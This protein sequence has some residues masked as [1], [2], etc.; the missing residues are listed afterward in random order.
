MAKQSVK[1]GEYILQIEDNGHVNVV[2]IPKN[3]KAAMIKIAEEKG[4]QYDPKW[5]TQY[6]GYALCK[7]YGD[8][9]TATF[10]D[11]T[12]T[13]QKNNKIEIV[14]ECK[15]VKGALKDI[16]DKMGFEYD[17]TWSTQY[18]GYRVAKYLVENKNDGEKILQTPN[19]I[20]S[21]SANNT[22]DWERYEENGKYGFKD[23]NGK[24]VIPCVYDRVGWSWDNGY[25]EVTIDDRKGYIDSDGKVVVPIDY[26][27]VSYESDQ[28]LFVVGK[29]EN[30][31]EMKYGILDSEGKQILPIE[32]DSIDRLRECEHL[33]VKLEG[34]LGLVSVSGEVVLPIEYDDVKDYRGAKPLLIKDGKS[35][36]IEKDG[37]IEKELPYDILENFDYKTDLALVRRDG[38]WGYVN[39]EFEEVVPCDYQNYTLSVECNP[40]ILRSMP[41]DAIDEE[42]FSCWKEDYEDS[43]EEYGI[44]EDDELN[45]NNVGEVFAIMEQNMFCEADDYTSF[46]D[47]VDSIKLFPRLSDDWFQDVRCCDD[48]VEFSSDEADIQYEDYQVKDNCIETVYKQAPYSCGCFY[49]LLIEDVEDFDPSQLR[50]TNP[51]EDSDHWEMPD[52]SYAGKPLKYLGNGF[53]EFEFEYNSARLFWDGEEINLPEKDSDYDDDEDW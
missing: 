16:C 5:N 17:P 3:A 30:W 36:V 6:F 44:S 11:I 43:F 15:P 14:Q 21:T 53:N 45:E 8:K 35:F 7:E 31:R 1:A 13:R 42:S 12:I 49:R 24:V 27:S 52:V 51:G 19:S 22:E 50:I 41:M 48:I 2:R 46:V 38:N 4:L 28:N 26:D 29:G 25:C 39:R 37:R 47:E 10:D 9:W 32:Y 40:F 18:F 23:E 34:K 20:P 33:L